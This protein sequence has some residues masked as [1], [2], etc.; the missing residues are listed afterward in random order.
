VRA[1][2]VRYA[3][4]A[5]DAD[6]LYQDVWLEVF[7][8]RTSFRGSGSLSGWILGIAKRTGLSWLRRED[9]RRRRRQRLDE[10]A[11]DVG[12]LENEPDLDGRLDRERALER[13]VRAVGSLPRDSGKPYR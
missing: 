7:E 6:D 10:A 12:R 1:L 2:I 11:V 4:D 9:A 3:P 13:V 5:A 8:K